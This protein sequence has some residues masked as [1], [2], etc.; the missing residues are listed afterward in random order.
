MFKDKITKREED[1]LIREW[2]TTI[3]YWAADNSILWSR[4]SVFILTNSILFALLA[5]APS[6]TFIPKWILN[7]LVPSLGV[8]INII[9]W[10][11]NLRSVAYTRH[12]EDLVT[13][14]RQQVPVLRFQDPELLNRQFRHWYQK[15]SGR[16]FLEFIPGLFL[17]FWIVVLFVL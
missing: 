15:M 10:L 6:D 2:E 7:C 3:N 11:I 1:V 14:I 4:C 9:W 8:V 13:Q 5:I 17:A 16:K 12:F